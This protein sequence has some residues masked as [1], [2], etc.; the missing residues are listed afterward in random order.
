M[1]GRRAGG[2]VR[3][4]GTLEKCRRDMVRKERAQERR[5]G[6]RETTCSREGSQLESRTAFLQSQENA[7]LYHLRLP[8]QTP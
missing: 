5:P 7:N 4:E 2:D 1:D 8:Y 6:T 3:E